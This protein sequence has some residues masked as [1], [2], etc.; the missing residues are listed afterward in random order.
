MEECRAQRTADDPQ[1]E[2]Q[3]RC[4][5]LPNNMSAGDDDGD[6]DDQWIHVALFF[7]VVVRH[8]SLDLLSFIFNSFF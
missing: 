1:A 5:L 7:V 4:A 3:C 8:R 2:R 6:D